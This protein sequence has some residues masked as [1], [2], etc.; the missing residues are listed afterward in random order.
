MSKRVLASQFS[1][2]KG[3][4]NNNNLNDGEYYYAELSNNPDDPNKKYDYQALGGLSKFHKLKITY[5]GNFVIAKKGDVGRGKKETG[6]QFAGNIRKIDLHTKTANA[7][8]FNGLDF[9]TIENA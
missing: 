9:V 7:L 8:K 3:C 5:N 1:D 2:S 4:Y 6:G